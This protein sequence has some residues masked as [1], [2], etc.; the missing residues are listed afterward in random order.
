MRGKK[1]SHPRAVEDGCVMKQHPGI[2]NRLLLNLKMPELTV[3]PV[4]SKFRCQS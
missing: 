3:G 2:E 4:L 1:L